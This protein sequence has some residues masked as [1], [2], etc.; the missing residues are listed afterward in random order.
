MFLW[1]NF[2]NVTQNLKGLLILSCCAFSV[3]DRWSPSALLW[4]RCREQQHSQRQYDLPLIHRCPKLHV[5]Q[6]WPVRSVVTC[7][8]PT[9]NQDEE[10]ESEYK[11]QRH[12]CWLFSNCSKNKSCKET[13]STGGFLIN[14]YLFWFSGATL[15]LC[16]QEWGRSNLAFE[17]LFIKGRTSLC[18]LHE[19]AEG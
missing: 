4:S 5:P 1:Q 7:M 16:P 19:S 14:T 8:R 6:C 9:A 13:L 10:M 12:W 18:I 17:N 11:V 15:L 2:L 3:A